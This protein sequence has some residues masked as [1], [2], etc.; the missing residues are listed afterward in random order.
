[1]ET[2]QKTKR[3]DVDSD[4]FTAEAVR[5]ARLDV[6]LAAAIID[7][8][9]GLVTAIVF[10]FGSL[11]SYL[12]VLDIITNSDNAGIQNE[13]AWFLLAPYSLYLLYHLLGWWSWRGQTFGKWTMGLKVINRRTLAP[14]GFKG[15]V[16]RTL[17]YALNNLLLPLWVVPLFNDE[18]RGLHDLIA[19]TVVVHKDTLP[20]ETAEAPTKDKRY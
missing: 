5:P 15:A 4:R 12:V 20:D 19:T 6:R 11:V 17:G 2:V 8:F 7:F 16:L 9:T 3:G 10:W 1:M 18:R 13:G 14:P